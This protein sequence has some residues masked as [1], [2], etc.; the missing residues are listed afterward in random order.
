MTHVGLTFVCVLFDGKKNVPEASRGFYTPQWVDK[1]WR[2]IRRWYS[3]PF[4]FVCLTDQPSGVFDED[5]EAIDFLDD[6][7]SW[8]NLMEMYRPELELGRFMTLGL[9]TVI[10]GSLDD[11]AGYEGHFGCNRDP[12][13]PNTYANGVTIV[14]GDYA[15]V[16]WE[17][18]QLHGD[19]TVAMCGSASELAWMRKFLP[20]PDILCDQFPGQIL[21]YSVF[22]RK[23]TE[24]GNTRVVGFHGKSKPHNCSSD[25]VLANWI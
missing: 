11:L 14:N 2:G 23:L 4:R 22:A 6:K 17:L 12:Y 8:L 19:E 13:N 20:R 15:R 24:P 21:S 5:V 1:L 3:R 16:I 25:W 10:T 18:W 7:H 9:D